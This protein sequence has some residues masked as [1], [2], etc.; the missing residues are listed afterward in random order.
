MH[1]EKR[2][3]AHWE[4]LRGHINIQRACMMR[5]KKFWERLHLNI[6]KDCL[7]TNVE[8]WCIR[9]L[10]RIGHWEWLR[11]HINIAQW[12][13]RKKVVKEC[14]SI[15]GKNALPLKKIDIEKGST[16]KLRKRNVRIGNYCLKSIENGCTWRLRKIAHIG[17]CS[18]PPL[19][20]PSHKAHHIR[21]NV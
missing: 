4:V 20:P 17:D 13:W 21:R 10:S 7:Q 9:R 11:R 14:K 6:E 19:S 12:N 15:L 5:L 18:S 1:I 8:K 16:W 3:N 2:K